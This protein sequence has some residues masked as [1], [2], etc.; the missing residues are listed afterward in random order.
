MLS[1]E[2]ICRKMSLKPESHDAQYSACLDVHLPQTNTVST[3]H[4]PNHGYTDKFECSL[5]ITHD[6]PPFHFG[7]FCA[8]KTKPETVPKMPKEPNYQFGPCQQ[9]PFKGCQ[10]E[11][12]PSERGKQKI[13]KLVDKGSAENKIQKPLKHKRSKLVALKK[14]YALL[15]K[16]FLNEKLEVDDFRYLRKLE[17]HILA[18]ILIRKN[19]ASSANR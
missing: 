10:L 1:A 3:L 17:I 4:T 2:S 11:F 12:S 19:R 15:T 9:Q 5:V 8:N 13:N 16:F 18:E 7:G 14:I 6:V